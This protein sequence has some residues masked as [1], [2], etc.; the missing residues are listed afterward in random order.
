MII[1]TNRKTHIKRKKISEA[2]KFQAIRRRDFANVRVIVK[3]L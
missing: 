2:E 1:W 3:L